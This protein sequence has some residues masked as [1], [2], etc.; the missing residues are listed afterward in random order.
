MR[1]CCALYRDTNTSSLSFVHYSFYLTFGIELRMHSKIGIKVE[2]LK[3]ILSFLSK[4]YFFL[5]GMIRLIIFSVSK[6]SISLTYKTYLN[7]LPIPQCI[8]TEF[9]DKA[10]LTFYTPYLSFL[11]CCKNDRKNILRYPNI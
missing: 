1:N 8:I 11:R 3:G 9:T 10:S 4:S 5:L 2:T 7:S 6:N